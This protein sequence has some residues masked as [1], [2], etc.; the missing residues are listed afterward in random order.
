MPIPPSDL[1][2]NYL[3]LPVLIRGELRLGDEGATRPHLFLGPSYHYS[4]G[5]RLSEGTN[6]TR[7]FRKQNYFGL[8]FGVGIDWR[9]LHIQVRFDEGLTNT[10]TDA[11]FNQLLLT[12][13][14][15]FRLGEE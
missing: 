4:V 3:T 11:N 2:L 13:G 14:H 12:L 9:K 8:V 10:E 5:C 6:C 1:D 15:A 7:L